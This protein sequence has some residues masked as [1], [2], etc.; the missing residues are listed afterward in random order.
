MGGYI[1]PMI[2]C[3]V[4]NTGCNAGNSIGKTLGAQDLHADHILADGTLGADC[5]PYLIVIIQ[6]TEVGI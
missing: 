3:K 1:T 6:P 5:I 2:S 4:V